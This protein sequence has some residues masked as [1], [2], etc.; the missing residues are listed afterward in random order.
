MFFHQLLRQSA[1][2]FLAV[3][4]FLCLFAPTPAGQSSSSEKVKT[5]QSKQHQNMRQQMR[6]KNNAQI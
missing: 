4:F 5:N 1:I 2:V 3:A 6:K